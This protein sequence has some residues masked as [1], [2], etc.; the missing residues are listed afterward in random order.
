[1]AEGAGAAGV[2]ALLA[3]KI[4]TQGKRVATVICGGNID[5]N[6]I[7]QVIECGLVDSGRRVR[8]SMD[9]PDRPGSLSTLMNQISDFKANV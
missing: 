1:M 3:G 8:Y 2:A 6:A 7:A 4:A 5:V 9:L